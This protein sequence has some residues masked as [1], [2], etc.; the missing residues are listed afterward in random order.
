MKYHC[1]LVEA[2]GNNAISY[3]ILAC[4]VGK[5]EQERVSTCDEQRSGRRVSVRTDLARAVIEQRMDEDGLWTLLELERTNGIE[6]RTI[7]RI[8]RNQLHLRKIAAKWVPHAITETQ[9]WF[10]MIRPLCTLTAGG[11]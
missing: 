5:F 8:L 10:D 9:R 7:H 11:D 6:K 1:D 4:W 3:G 2:T